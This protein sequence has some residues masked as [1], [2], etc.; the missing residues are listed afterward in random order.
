MARMMFV[1]NFN[2]PSMHIISST[3][4]LATPIADVIPIASNT[5]TAPHAR[6]STYLSCVDALHR[7]NIESQ[8]YEQE[9]TDRC[10]SARRN[11]GCFAE[12]QQNRRVRLREYQ[13]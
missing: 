10:T 1:S 11:T 12:W 5:K 8:I 6:Q 13:L 7:K 9:T 3:A 2:T 4:A